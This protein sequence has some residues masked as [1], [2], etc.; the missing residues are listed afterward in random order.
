MCCIQCVL[1]AMRNHLQSLEVQVAATACIY[2]LTTYEQ[3][4]SLHPSLMA[5]VVSTILLCMNRALAATPREKQVWI[6]Q[7]TF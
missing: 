2:Y 6:V 7:L 5:D 1:P 3:N 4:K